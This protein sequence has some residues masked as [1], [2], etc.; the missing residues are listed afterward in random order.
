MLVMLYFLEKKSQYS[1]YNAEHYFCMTQ[2]GVE[3][4]TLTGPVARKL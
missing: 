4:M 1:P 3:P 2:P